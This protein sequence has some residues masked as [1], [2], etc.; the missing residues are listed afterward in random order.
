VLEWA[1]EQFGPD[2]WLAEN[3]HKLA[4]VLA[5][6][7]VTVTITWSY[8]R[9]GRGLKLYEWCLKLL[10][11]LIV[12]CFIGVV[13]TL[14]LSST[15]PLDWSQVFAGF[16][17]DFTKF[18]RPADGFLPLLEA[19]GPLGDPVRAFW[20]ERIVSQ[21]R[22]VM[23][24]AAATAVGINMT[25][26]F[27]Y[28][29]LRKRWTKHHRGLAIFDLSTGMFIPYVLA[30]SCVVIAAASQFHTE[31]G[32]GFVVAENEVTPPA[33]FEA[34]YN[35][36]L[37]AREN[38]EELPGE[39]DLAE[40]RLAATLVQRDAIDLSTSLAPLTG[41]VVANV[42]FG[43]GVLAMVLSTISL[44]MLISGQVFCE[45]L[46]FPQG[47]WPHRIGTLVAGV[48]GTLG[49][50]VWSQAG[51]YLAV[52]TSVFGFVLLP[53]AYITFF[54]LMNQKKLLGENAPRGMRRVVWNTLMGVAATVAS[55]GA[56]YMVWDK[57]KWIG[58]A[59]V[60][61]FILLALMV[62]INRWN[63]ARYGGAGVEGRG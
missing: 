53:F 50:F 13:I 58:I 39:I 33:K 40:K 15:R 51:F 5:I 47:G 59:V 20:S 24:S 7:L 10:V 16:V 56:V 52:P 6:F 28:S 19:I 29:M 21:Q 60:A 17:P 41:T 44:L 37:A 22:D 49:P 48:G 45:I 31:V 14:S 34:G 26:L 4:I 12:A 63:E 27:P 11:G 54:L 57:A 61:G 43:V 1:A 8:D 9:G 42:I 30:T 32:D 46:G 55:V 2:H 25:F 18:Y 23:I 3:A 38:A 35:G 62:Q 36:L